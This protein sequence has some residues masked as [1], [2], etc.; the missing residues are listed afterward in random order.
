MKEG[1]EHIL[2]SGSPSC[3]SREDR[4]EEDDLEEE[5]SERDEVF[6]CRPIRSE[7]R[8]THRQR[9]K[10]REAK[11]IAS[12]ISNFLCDLYSSKKTCVLLIE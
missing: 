9:R 3:P 4:I 1:M 8:K 6:R 2:F 12:C 7:D 5:K 11:E 10:E